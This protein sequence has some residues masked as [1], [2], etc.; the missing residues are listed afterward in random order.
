MGLPNFAQIE[1]SRLS[2]ETL[3]P[4]PQTSK[5]GAAGSCAPS[6]SREKHAS[7]YLPTLCYVKHLSF[8]SIKNKDGY[9]VTVQTIVEAV[10][11]VG[12][13][14]DDHIGQ[15]GLR[16]PTSMKTRISSGIVWP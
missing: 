4:D 1:V 9:Q 8:D 13:T 12:A 3:A 7:A 5:A 15:R 10:D 6:A 14:D 2:A 11:L 16:C